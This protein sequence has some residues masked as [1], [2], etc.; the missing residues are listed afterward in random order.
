MTK[1]RNPDHPIESL[2][3]KRW[4]PRAYDASKMPQNDL[5]VILE[6]ARWAPSAYNIQPWRFLYSMRD[7]QHWQKYLTLLDPFN[8]QWAQNA[9][10][11]VI[12][13]SDR[14]MPGGMS[15]HEKKSRTHSFDA[16]AAWAQLALQATSL[17]YQAHAMAG[18][19]F[20]E[21]R[22]SLSI[23]ENYHIEI[24]VAIGK[25]ADPSKLPPELRSREIPSQRL[26]IEETSFF[27]TLPQ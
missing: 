15:P 23:P 21:I 18:I 3:F 6:A 12:I 10:A 9:S 5:N 13:I 27:G 7:D 26:P 1:L 2:F 4:S 19:Y 16:G 20:D 8:K 22:K 17:G 14:L 11:L 25:A 24:A